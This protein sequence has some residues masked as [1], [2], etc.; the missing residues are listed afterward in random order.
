MTPLPIVISC[1]ASEAVLGSTLANPQH[2]SMSL[3]A[4]GKPK[5]N[6]SKPRKISYPA[7]ILSK[8]NMSSFNKF[9]VTIPLSVIL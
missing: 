8:F 5:E 9:A 6:S 3:G 1:V 7:T 4:S 2:K